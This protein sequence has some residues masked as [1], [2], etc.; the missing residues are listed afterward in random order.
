MDSGW[1]VKFDE[2]KEGRGWRGPAKNHGDSLTFEPL[3]IEID[4]ELE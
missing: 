1:K 2:G 3:H 4:V